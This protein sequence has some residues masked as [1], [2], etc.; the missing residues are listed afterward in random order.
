MRRSR[1]G[2]SEDGGREGEKLE[3][4]G[5][6]DGGLPLHLPYTC[7][8]PALHLLFTCPTPA[9]HLPYTDLAEASCDLVVISMAC[10]AEC[11]SAVYIRCKVGVNQVQSRCKSRCKA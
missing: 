1:G 9:L 10:R 5:R 4:G 3:K 2:D 11:E 6:P 7:L 8:T